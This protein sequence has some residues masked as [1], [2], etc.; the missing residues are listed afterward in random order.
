MEYK[1]LDQKVT[2]EIFDL[3]MKSDN[4]IM[5]LEEIAQ[6]LLDELTEVLDSE[7]GPG[8]PTELEIRAKQILSEV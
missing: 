6:E 7:W 1:V 8:N 4:R 5:E 3:V 2:K